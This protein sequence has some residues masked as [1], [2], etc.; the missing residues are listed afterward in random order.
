MVPDLDFLI[1]LTEHAGQLLMQGYLKEHQIRHKG[2]IDLVTEM[3]KRSEDYLLGEIRAAFPQHSIITEES[4]YLAGQSEHCWFID[5]LDGTS[6]YAHGVPIF[7]VT[8]AYAF[9]GQVILGVTY[10]P[11]RQHCFCAERGQGSYL[12]NTRVHVSDKTDLL[13]AMLV[14]G[15]PYETDGL[16]G[17]NLDHFTT[18]LQRSQAIRRLGSAAIDIAYVAAGWVDGYWEI[19]IHPWDI[20]AGTLLVEEAGGMVTD[21]QGNRDYFKPPYAMIAANPALHEKMSAAITSDDETRN[22]VAV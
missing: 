3:D 7:S 1:R 2:R 12:N 10:D 11:T 4:G 17:N 13:D 5:P 22:D 16:H 9:Q 19:G 6:N 14:T 8:M 20:A 15:F 21:L 18:F